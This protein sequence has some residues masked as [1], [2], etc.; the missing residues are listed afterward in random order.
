MSDEDDKAA[1]DHRAGPLEI[2]ATIISRY[3]SP[4]Y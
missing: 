4:R 1:S 2:V 3:S